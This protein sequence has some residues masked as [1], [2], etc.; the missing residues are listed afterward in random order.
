MTVIDTAAALFLVAAA[1]TMTASLRHRGDVAAATS[2]LPA[3]LM[4]CVATATGIAHRIDG[5]VW[6]FQWREQALGALR[7]VLLISALFLG[8]IVQA[9]VDRYMRGGAPVDTACTPD[10]MLASLRTLVV[11]PF[12]EE[13]VFRACVIAILHD[14]GAAPASLVWASPLCFGLAHLHNVFHVRYAPPAGYA[15]THAADQRHPPRAP[16]GIAVQIALVQVCYTY[17]FGVIAAHLYVSTGTF[18]APFV[19]HALCNYLGLPRVHEIGGGARGMLVW[20]A[21]AA[22]IALFASMVTALY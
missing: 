8:P 15:S 16:W 9:A 13:F 3:S 10:D 22:G 1:L 5:G 14:G 2:A 12:A 11:A 6:M 18:V 20:G 19:A 7:A 4:E 17:I 21:Y